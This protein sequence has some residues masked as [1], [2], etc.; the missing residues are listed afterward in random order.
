VAKK[1]QKKNPFFSAATKGGKKLGPLAAL[2]GILTLA[3][4]VLTGKVDLQQL[5]SLDSIK[6][7]IS[8]A[9]NSQ[10]VV[11]SDITP[12]RLDQNAPKPGDRLRVATF[13]IQRFG[14]KK[15]ADAEVMRNIARIVSQFDLV[16]IQE[17]QSPDSMPVARL[18]DLINR[19]GGR[20]D[21]AVSE[22]IGRTTYLEQ[23]AM[24]W[25]TTRVALIPE[26]AYLVRDDA[27]RMHRP[28]MVASFETRIPPP[29]GDRPFRFTVI[30]AHT[31]PS[32]VSAKQISSEMNVLDDVFIR[33]R[34]YEYK[35]RGIYNVILVGDLN[36]STANLGELGQIPGIIT[37]VGT[38][39]TNTAG[40]KTYDHIILDGNVTTEYTHVFGVIDYERDLGLTPE[41]AL[42]VSD[43]RPVWAEFSA[44]ET[45]P[46]PIATNPNAQP[47]NRP[48]R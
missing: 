19:S 16:A 33:V 36:V 30:S 6:G 47:V 35:T 21:A 11:T 25:D 48:T 10:S 18:V 29:P 32:E 5:S 43:H 3:G 22:P 2:T 7:L 8:Q 24:V 28:P 4:A 34:E 26:S 9:D 38:T 37:V 1:S 17:V 39:P 20:Y 13:N 44:F 42:A 31:D 45:P 40:T 46:I 41:Q 23:Y 12:V 27:D 14:S 15:S